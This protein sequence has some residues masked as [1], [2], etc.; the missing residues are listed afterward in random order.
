MA[1][2]VKTFLIVLFFVGFSSCLTKKNITIPLVYKLNENANFK[3]EIEQGKS[4]NHPSFVIWM[5]D[6]NENFI[7]TLFITK[8]YASGIF[9][10]KMVG[11][12]MW[13]NVSGKSIQPAAMP[14]W[15]HKKGLINNKTLIP[16]PE[17]PY[18]DAYSGAT[19]TGRFIF[20]DTIQKKPK[21]RV[22][23]EVNQP[24]DWNEY[25]INSKFPN[26]DAYKHSAQPS[27]IYSTVINS[28]DS[29]FYLNPIGHGSPTG[30]DGK[31]YTDLSTLTSAL[32]I[33]SSIKVIA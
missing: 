3:I 5:E 31:L 25:W 1:N 4:F 14:Y 30:E 32:D 7:K 9:G 17:N 23:L 16:T 20:S 11:D 22:L 13:L 21:F 15:T 6:M 18:V 26:S 24:W 28:T 19:P 10:H 2:L 8:S 12:S 33:F 29:I 27:L